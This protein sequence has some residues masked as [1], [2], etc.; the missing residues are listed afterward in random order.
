M[1]DVSRGDTKSIRETIPGE[2]ET[3]RQATRSNIVAM[4]KTFHMNPDRLD[5]CQM[6]AAAGQPVAPDAAGQSGEEVLDK[7]LKG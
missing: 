3:T 6:Q 4:N 5:R 1:R 2:L 7:P